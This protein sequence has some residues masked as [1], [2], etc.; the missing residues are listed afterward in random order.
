MDFINLGP[1][2]Q[3]FK[4][5]LLFLEINCLILV[6]L[7]LGSIVILVGQPIFLEFCITCFS[8]P[9]INTIN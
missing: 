8:L 4:F 1:L 7:S 9:F 2:G 6:Y 3:L 5:F